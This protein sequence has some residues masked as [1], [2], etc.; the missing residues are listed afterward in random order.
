MTAL[1]VLS[2]LLTLLVLLLAVPV[3]LALQIERKE[4]FKGQISI[5]WLFGLVRFRIP[6]PSDVKRP[7][8]SGTSKRPNEARARRGKRGSRSD[9][10]VIFRQTAFRQRVYRFVKDLL[11]AARLRQLRLSMRLGL[12][13]PADTGCLW[14]LVGPLNAAGQNLRNAKVLIEPEFM[15]SVCEFQA[16]ARMHLIPL[17]LLALAIAF[18]LSPP[19]IHAWRTLSG[20]RA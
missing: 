12:G 19:T 2:G 7:A 11:R 3:D 10:L 6:V 1:L 15:D 18:A 20:S 8:R 4:T 9:V 16:H 5:R 13:D 17:Q 14:A